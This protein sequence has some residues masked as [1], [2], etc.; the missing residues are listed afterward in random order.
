MKPKFVIIEQHLSGIEEIGHFVPAARGLLNCAKNYGYEPYLV[1][2]NTFANENCEG[3]EII[4]HYSQ[5]DLNK[6][7]SKFNYIKWNQDKLKVK[8]KRN[9]MLFIKKTA[10]EYYKKTYFANKKFA[11]ETINLFNLLSLSNH[12]IVYFSFINDWEVSALFKYIHNNKINNLPRINLLLWRNIFATPSHKESEEKSIYRELKRKYK[13]CIKY[14]GKYDVGLFTDSERRTKQYNEILGEYFKTIPMSLEIKKNEDFNK[15]NFKTND[16]K[17]LVSLIGHARLDKG[18][19]LIPQIIKT[20]NEYKALSTKIIFL[21]QAYGETNNPTIIDI[22]KELKAE[23]AE[24]LQLI[25]KRLDDYE[26]SKIFKKTDII[27]LPYDVKTYYVQTSG[28]F[29]EAM[30][31]GI[32]VIVPNETWMSMIIIKE[33]VKYIERIIDENKIIPL[34]NKNKIPIDKS[35]FEVKAFSAYKAKG[36]ILKIEHIVKNKDFFLIVKVEEYSKE[37]LTY[38]SEFLVE[39]VADGKGCRYIRW[40][41]DTEKLIVS[42]RDKYNDNS[43]TIDSFQIYIIENIEVEDSI[44]GG[45]YENL[46]EIPKLLEQ[47]TDKYDHYRRSAIEYSKEFKKT[48]GN[49]ALLNVLKK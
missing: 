11:K 47:M 20:T 14:Y 1:A 10:Y 40:Q 26:Y 8:V 5:D 2:D 38:E 24:N 49:K 16:K 31:E 33:Y 44:I 45:M 25:T 27:L 41:A 3:I 13:L 19:R 9:I 18:Y 17:Y 7:K 23:K 37:K 35:F 34:A 32:P 30:M 15:H 29:K 6:I 21:V 43:S 36:C 12:D 46:G 28:P 4:S 39:I 48:N 22:I 42:V